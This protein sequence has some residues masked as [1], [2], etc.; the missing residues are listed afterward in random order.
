VIALGK[1]GGN[2]LNYSSDIDVVF[3]HDPARSGEEG[4]EALERWAKGFLRALSA[5]GANGKMFRVDAQLRPWGGQ[6]GLVGSVASYLDYYSTH[7]DGWELQSWLK[8]RALAGNL[9][10]GRDLV[11]RIQA[12]TTA[13]DNLGKITASMRKVRL[14][15]LEKLKQENRLSSEVKLGPGGIRTI[16]FYVQYQQVLHGRELPELVGGNTLAA[17]GK[18]W[19]YRLISASLHD[20]LSRSYVFLRRIEHALQLQGMQ[21]RHALPDSPEELEKLARRMGFEERLGQPAAE[22][23]RERYRRHMLTLQEL[24]SDLF[25]YDT[26]VPRSDS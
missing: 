17:L 14:M 9:E 15:G 20:T 2:E 22:Q 23:F 4:R 10:M 1:L 19:R 5:P 3:V 26:N 24:S 8:A 21:Q 25:Q 6:S 18:L 16:E 13:P 12:F 7:A 11:K